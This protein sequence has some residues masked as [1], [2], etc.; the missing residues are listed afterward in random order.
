MNSELT[1]IEPIN[2]S[3]NTNAVSKETFDQHI[4][5]YNGYVKK[6]NTISSELYKKGAAP[7]DEN[8]FRGLKTG[9]TYCLDGV[10]L[11]E[12]YFRGMTTAKT[13]PMEKTK[14]LLNQCF[15]SCDD[16]I[17]ALKTCAAAARGWCVAAYDQRTKS[18]RLFMQDTHDTGV[19]AAAFPILVLDV[20]EHAYYL[21]YKTNKGKYI[22]AYVESIDWRRVEAC[23]EK[24][25]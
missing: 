4:L 12:E 23:V 6:T 24:I 8:E 15:G 14:E 25:I 17:S 18:L 13:A 11:H 20:Y 7:S 10:I 3:Y 1:K 2:F 21:D 16:F 22:D 19:V 9:E 5:L